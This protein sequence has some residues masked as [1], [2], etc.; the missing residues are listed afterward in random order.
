MIIMLDGANGGGKTTY[1]YKLSEKLGV[2]VCRV[3]RSSN[4]ELHWGSSGEELRKELEA[5]RVP[6]NTHVD[7][8]FMADFMR[9]FQAES[10]LDRTIASAI[11]YGR[12]YSHLDGWYKE[13]GNARRLLE[14]WMSLIGGCKLPIVYVWLDVTYEVARERCEGRWCPNRTEYERLRREYE[15]VFHR[16]R[17]RKIRI[18]ADNVSVDSGVSKI[19]T[20]TIPNS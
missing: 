17:F 7:D 14:F 2:N 3:F 12:V 1:A 4:K 20:G 15:R 11:V 5:L 6:I 18:D 13:K 16:I 8:I 9:S 10:I 19:I